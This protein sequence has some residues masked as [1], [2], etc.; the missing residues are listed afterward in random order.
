M[1]TAAR[2]FRCD[3][4]LPSYDIGLLILLPPYDIELLIPFNDSF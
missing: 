1:N 3:Y 4:E 2:R